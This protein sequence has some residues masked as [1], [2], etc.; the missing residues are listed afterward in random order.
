[1]LWS[2]FNYSARGSCVWPSS[3]SKNAC[4]SASSKFFDGLPSSSVS[5]IEITILKLFKPHVALRTAQE[6]CLRI[7]LQAF[8]AIR[9]HCSSDGEELA[10]RRS[11]EL[12][13]V[14]RRRT[15][16]PGVPDEPFQ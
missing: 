13:R 4:S 3:S 11:S 5:H 12:L 14:M 7:L 2:T 8:E 6:H 1:M 16:S 9:Q 15:E 10:G